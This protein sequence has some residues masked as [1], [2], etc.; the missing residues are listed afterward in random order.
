MAEKIEGGT[1]G[2]A[3]DDAEQMI[4]NL[5]TIDRIQIQGIAGLM[6][7][8]WPIGFVSDRGAIRL[9]LNYDDSAFY[10]DANG[11]LSLMTPLRVNPQKLAPR[12]TPLEVDFAAGKIAFNGEEFL[13]QS[14]NSIPSGCIVM[15]SGDVNNIPSG[16]ALCDGRNGT[17][18]L[19]DRFVLGAGTNNVGSTGGSEKVSLTA[20][21]MPT[22]YH[23]ISVSSNASNLGADSI[24]M[25]SGG[26]KTAAGHTTNS[27]KGTAHD[28]MPSYYTLAFIMKM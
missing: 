13:F 3:T 27:G 16:W 18:D 22:H 4:E 26:D 7:P 14:G 24:G 17:P 9:N 23:H 12:G 1:I 25:V 21:Q 5:D 28:N 2:K 10:S 11:N 20:D 15:W 19:R 6:N 8:V